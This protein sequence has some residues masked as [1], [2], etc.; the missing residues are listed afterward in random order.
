MTFR[1]DVKFVRLPPL[2][3]GA[4]FR[5]VQ[6]SLTNACRHSQATR[7]DIELTQQDDRV[8]LTIRD[9]GIGF[10]RS[11]VPDDRF[12]LR[13][14]IERA[15]LFG[16]RSQIRSEPGTGTEIWA[17]LPINKSGISS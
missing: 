8:L 14:L 4:L 9:N 5:I 1:Y 11:A 17:D 15:R 13:G 12:G 3:E 16:G 2:L 7:V 10:D 6:E